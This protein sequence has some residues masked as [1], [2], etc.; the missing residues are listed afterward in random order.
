MATAYQ[1][2]IAKRDA[3][4]AAMLELEKSRPS[5]A[6]CEHYTRGICTKFGERPPE[7]FVIGPTECPEFLLDQIP[8]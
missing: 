5:C 1:Q 8:F 2:W 7:H 3:L 6:K 4:D